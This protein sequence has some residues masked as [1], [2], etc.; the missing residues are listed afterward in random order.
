MDKVKQKLDEELKQITFSSNQK[1]LNKIKKKSVYQKWKDL[2]NNEVTIPLIPVT[3]IAMGL[4][5]II[6][7]YPI[8]N[9]NPTVH[10]E[11]Y[12]VENKIIERAG[13]LYWESWFNEVSKHES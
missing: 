5:A 2:L 11:E 3:G 13:S 7:I 1:V 10:K 12:P 9:N 8:I 4:V 6:S